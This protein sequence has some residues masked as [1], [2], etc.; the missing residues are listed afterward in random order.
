[1]EGSEKEVRERDFRI[2]EEGIRGRDG[3]EGKKWESGREG[4]VLCDK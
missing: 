1:M 4:S 2:S 3:V